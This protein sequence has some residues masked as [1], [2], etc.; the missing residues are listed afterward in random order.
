VSRRSLVAHQAIR[1]AIPTSS[2]SRYCSTGTRASLQLLERSRSARRLVRAALR[3][4]CVYGCCGVEAR[5]RRCGFVS[6]R[7]HAPHWCRSRPVTHPRRAPRALA[8]GGQDMSGRLRGL[9]LRAANEQVERST[10]SPCAGEVRSSGRHGNRCARSATRASFFYGHLPAYCVLA[11]IDPS[12]TIS[13]PRLVRVGD[14]VAVGQVDPGDRFVRSGE[15]VPVAM[16]VIRVREPGSMRGRDV[17][18]SRAER[19]RPVA[20][21]ARSREAAVAGTTSG[22]L[23][24]G[25][26]VTW[27]ARHLGIRND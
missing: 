1:L 17:L 10:L 22:L 16:P 7:A 25:D 26:E 15:Y 4:V 27:E 5:R 14:Q 18:R 24:L 2:R 3:R 20:S 9:W 8:G 11:T 12:A 6:G 13:P 23:E 21:T 19:R